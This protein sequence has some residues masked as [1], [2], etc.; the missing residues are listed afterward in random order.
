MAEQTNYAATIPDSYAFARAKLRDSLLQ[1]NDLPCDLHSLS[2]RKA[3][4]LDIAD[5]VHSLGLT[6]QD[7]KFRLR[8]YTD[9][10]LKNPEDILAK[11]KD[12][13]GDLDMEVVRA[14]RAKAGGGKPD[15][16][17]MPGCPLHRRPYNVLVGG[18]SIGHPDE[19]TGT[20]GYFCRRANDSAS[21]ILSAG[22]VF[23]E[24]EV[25]QPGPRD[26]FPFLV[27]GEPVAK[28]TH[29]ASLTGP[30]P[31]DA[32][33]A[34]VLTGYRPEI[35]RIG[36]ADA[37]AGA[38]FDMAVTKVG[39][40]T[41]YT[42]GT[43]FE[44]RDSRIDVEGHGRVLFQDLLVIR[45]R[46]RHSYFGRPGDSG[47]LVVSSRDRRAVGLYFA[48]AKDGSYSLA[49]PIGPILAYFGAELII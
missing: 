21:Y 46:G 5:T 17:F 20:L 35:L 38:E 18:I 7:G 28:V 22:H 15:R 29:R 36:K 16:R 14:E 26:C 44:I 24:D 31:L 30:Y 10:D 49:Q 45:K 33:V 37:P 43:I 11:S 9:R 32:A 1:S 3:Q 2:R 27:K 42:D 41:G 47:A 25:F 39:R 19:Q 4:P 13:V 8:I 34:E 12:L 40:T 23:R 48:G 6:R